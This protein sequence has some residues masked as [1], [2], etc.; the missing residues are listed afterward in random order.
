VHVRAEQAACTLFAESRSNRSTLPCRPRSRARRGTGAGA[1]PTGAADA[2]DRGRRDCLGH[3][4]E[5]L[6]AGGL[7]PSNQQVSDYWKAVYAANSEL[8]GDDPNR[9]SV[10][11]VLQLPPAP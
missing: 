9:L 6:E 8:L 1:R 3:R 5:H 4:R 7:A 2:H 11:A 10:G